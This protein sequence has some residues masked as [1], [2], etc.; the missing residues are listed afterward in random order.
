MVHLWKQFA[1]AAVAI[2][3]FAT[4]AQAQV[5][6]QLPNPHAATCADFHHHRS[7]GTWTPKVEM[8]VTS[9]TGT[10]SLGP[11]NS[12]AAGQII[13]GRDLG[14]WLDDTCH[15]SKVW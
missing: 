13:G 9:A 8:Q 14:K 12:F 1:V 3:A 2:L 11:G 5:I 15:K 10:V 6:A 7:A 4:A